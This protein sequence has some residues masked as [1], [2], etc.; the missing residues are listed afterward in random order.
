MPSCNKRFPR[1]SRS[2]SDATD[3]SRIYEM[4]A[5]W[6]G[7][8]FPKSARIASISALLALTGHAATAK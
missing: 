1:N 8:A 3:Y 5:V 6:E 7:E 4:N 2:A